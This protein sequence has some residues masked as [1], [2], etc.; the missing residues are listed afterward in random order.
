MEETTKKINYRFLETSALTKTGFFLGTIIAALIW[1][2]YVLFN[3][4]FYSPSGS[5]KAISA[6]L[7]ICS[8]GIIVINSFTLKKEK[9]IYGIIGL[10]FSILAL[11]GY[12]WFTLVYLYIVYL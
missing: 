4:V 12:S 6:V 9:T 11:L 2:Q 1:L 10:I 8:V 7:I 3:F 5:F